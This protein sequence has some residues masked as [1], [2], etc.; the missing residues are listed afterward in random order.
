MKE[1]I[2]A[3]DG[4]GDLDDPDAEY[5]EDKVTALLYGFSEIVVSGSLNGPDLWFGLTTL[6]LKSLVLPINPCTVSPTLNVPEVI[7]I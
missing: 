5:E 1:Q 7:E 6:P 2:A 3:E 4:V